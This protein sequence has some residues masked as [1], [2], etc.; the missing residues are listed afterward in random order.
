MSSSNNEKL[1]IVQNNFSGTIRAG[2][3]EMKDCTK[4]EIVTFSRRVNV[5]EMQ[6][7]YATNTNAMQPMYKTNV[8]NITY[9]HSFLRHTLQ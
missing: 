3:N 1:K 7:S 9:S 8:S 5:G 2:I 6:F 4:N